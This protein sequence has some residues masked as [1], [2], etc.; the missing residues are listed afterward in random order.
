MANR[1]IVLTSLP[2]LETRWSA[3]A[4][5]GVS[6]DL[7][8]TFLRKTPAILFPHV[9]SASPKSKSSGK[10]RAAMNTRSDVRLPDR[11][12]TPAPVTIFDGQGRVVRVVPA[13]EFRR[14]A[15]SSVRSTVSDERRGKMAGKAGMR[16]VMVTMAMGSLLLAP[17]LVAA[18]DAV[19]PDRPIVYPAPASKNAIGEAEHQLKDF[20]TV[21]REQQ[22][23]RDQ[24]LLNEGAPSTLPRPDLGED[25]TSGIQRGAIQSVVPR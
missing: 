25:V 3:V 9:C 16:P 13:A 15:V 2:L 19:Q 8:Y 12:E 1:F 14:A 4:M 24:Q 10:G 22:F 20:E 17:T 7:P 11:E 5:Q 23:L 6:S 18:Q 21:R